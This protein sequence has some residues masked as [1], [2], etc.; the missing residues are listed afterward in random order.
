MTQYRIPKETSKYFVPEQVYLTVVHFCRQYPLWK[1]ELAVEPDTSKA[2]DYSTDRVQTSNQYD[3]SSELAI[4]RQMICRKKDTVDDVAQRV[5][6]NMSKWLI[7]GVGY[8]LTYYQLKDRG[9]P[10]GK[11]LYSSLRQRFY[12]EMSKLI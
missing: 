11:N 5:A 8:G 10:C 4:R 2:I 1:A 3:P 12:Y 9:I 7:L 6:G